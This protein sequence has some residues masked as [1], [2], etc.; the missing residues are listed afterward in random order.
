MDTN[1]V[2]A[3]AILKVLLSVRFFIYGYDTVCGVGNRRLGTLRE[4]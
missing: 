1:Y 2:S 4:T 3:R